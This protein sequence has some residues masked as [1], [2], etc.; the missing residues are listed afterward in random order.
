MDVICMNC[1]FGVLP[2]KCCVALHYQNEINKINVKM[3]NLIIEFSYSLA[4]L[5]E[6]V[7]RILNMR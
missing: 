3:S 4:K 7:G 2:C 6:I 5:Y 1:D